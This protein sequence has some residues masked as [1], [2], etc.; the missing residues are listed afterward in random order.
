MMTPSKF[1]SGD[2]GFGGVR[3]ILFSLA[4]VPR[5]ILAFT[6]LWL[7]LETVSGC[8]DVADKARSS[9]DYIWVLHI[10]QRSSG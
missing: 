2:C 6:F 8:N 9:F 1:H 3:V 7:S 10:E 4:P 5:P